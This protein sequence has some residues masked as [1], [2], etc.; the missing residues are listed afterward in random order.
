MTATSQPYEQAHSEP[1]RAPGP[2][3]GANTDLSEPDRQDTGDLTLAVPV[4]L[5]DVEGV[6]S[7][8]NLTG[9]LRRAFA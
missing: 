5:A 8:R 6:R 4:E 2:D 9:L 1:R 7:T 3:L